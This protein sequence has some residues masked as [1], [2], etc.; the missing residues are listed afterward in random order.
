MSIATAS[1][2]AGTAYT[3][4]NSDRR[5]M[6]EEGLGCIISGRAFPAHLAHAAVAPSSFASCEDGIASI[7]RGPTR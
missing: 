3:A 7:L 4:S 6:L 5:A 2:V 1:P